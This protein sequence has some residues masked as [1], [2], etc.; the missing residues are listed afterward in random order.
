MILT[1]SSLL[2]VAENFSETPTNTEGETRP[3]PRLKPQLS[4]DIRNFTEA[5]LQVRLGF[6][7]AVASES[8]P[9]PAELGE[10]VPD[11]RDYGRREQGVGLEGQ[12]GGWTHAKVRPSSL[13]RSVASFLV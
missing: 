10:S 6:E 9:E 12:Y 5:L 7:F 2:V 1:R 13:N 4:D 11:I 3:G 8:H